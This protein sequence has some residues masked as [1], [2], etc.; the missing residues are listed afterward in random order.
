MMAPNLYHVALTVTP[1]IPLSVVVTTADPDM[2]TELN[3]LGTGCC[4]KQR[5]AQSTGG[6]ESK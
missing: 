3:L 4:G 6:D 1:M 5:E 2:D